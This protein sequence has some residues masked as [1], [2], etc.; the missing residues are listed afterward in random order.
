MSYIDCN[1]RLF[2]MSLKMC[3]T[4]TTLKLI[5]TLKCNVSDVKYINMIKAI[6]NHYMDFQPKIYHDV[7]FIN[8]TKNTIFHI[9]DDRGCDVLSSDKESIGHLYK[10]YNDWILDYGRSAID[11]TFQ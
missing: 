4:S 10:N 11:K 8:K 2:H 1:I 5:D 3:T 7:F 9:Y 6:C